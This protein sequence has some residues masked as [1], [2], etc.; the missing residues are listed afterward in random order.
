VQRY[1]SEA[2][3][4]ALL[5]IPLMEFLPPEHPKVAG[6]LEAI[7]QKLV[8]NGLVYR[9]EP[10]ATLGGDQLPIGE[11]EGAFLPATFWYAHALAKCGRIDEAEA[12]L[13]KCE[14]IAG[15]LGL[16]AEEADPRDKVFLGNTTLLFAQVEYA[17]AV[18]EVAERRKNLRDRKKGNHGKS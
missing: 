11:Y 8:V 6:M 2:L 5:L 12:I 14:S 13:K 1:D 18:R 4:A 10:D 3:D 9:F 16:F 7:E 17:R 15:E